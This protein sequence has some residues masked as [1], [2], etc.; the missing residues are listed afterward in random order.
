MIEKTYTQKDVD[1]L[2]V[3]LRERQETLEAL[4][5]ARNLMIETKQYHRFI[6][7]ITH[8][9]RSIEGFSSAPVEKEQIDK[10]KEV[11]EEKTEIV[12]EIVEHKK[13]K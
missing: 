8:I 12:E 10:N 6:S 11:V 5:C 2:V 7:R 4:E 13:K 3:S 9:M 1:D